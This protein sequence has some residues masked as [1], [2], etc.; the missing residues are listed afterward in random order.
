MQQRMRGRST[1]GQSRR[2]ATACCRGSHANLA[3]RRPIDGY[4]APARVTANGCIGIQK[5]VSCRVIDLTRQADKRAGRRIGHEPVLQQVAER[6]GERQRAGDFRRQHAQGLLQILVRQQRIVDGAGG[7]QDAVQNTEF[8][9]YRGRERTHARGVRDIA[10]F[11]SQPGAAR[12]E[13]Q[14]R[15]EQC[16]IRRARSDQRL[17]VVPLGQRLAREQNE[18]HSGLRRQHPRGGQTQPA[19]ATRDQVDAPITH[20]GVHHVRGRRFGEAHKAPCK[21]ATAAQRNDVGCLRGRRPAGDFRPDLFDQLRA[22]ACSRLRRF[23]VHQLPMP[24]RDFVRQ[25]RHRAQ[26]Q[27]TERRAHAFRADRHRLWRQHRPAELLPVLIRCVLR[28]QQHAVECQ[29]PLLGVSVGCSAQIQCQC[30]NDVSRLPAAV[31][32]MVQQLRQV[33]GLADGHDADLRGL[34]GHHLR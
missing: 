7:M 25:H 2:L 3:P 33:T 29:R 8:R 17:P 22:R 32:D 13:V 6:A 5:S 16:G 34:R 20:A 26:R 15:R 27:R 9:A 28:Q 4:E 21:A 10:R 31:A 23:H 14:Q 1:R 24:T 11:Q 19:G 18:R 30:V 12:L